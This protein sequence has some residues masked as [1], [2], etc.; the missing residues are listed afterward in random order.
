MQTEKSSYDESSKTNSTIKSSCGNWTNGLA[1][2]SAHEVTHRCETFHTIV[3]SFSV[4]ITV[5]KRGNCSLAHTI[6]HTADM[7]I[8]A[9]Q[10]VYNTTDILSVE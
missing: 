2:G 4:A 6:L 7:T 5:Q 1:R 10:N 9:V 3:V 8:S